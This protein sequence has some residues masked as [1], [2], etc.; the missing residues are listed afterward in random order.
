MLLARFSTVDRTKFA[1]ACTCRSGGGAAAGVA[2]RQ[3]D[4]VPVAVELA[5]F[6]HTFACQL[7]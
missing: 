4:R 1:M 2:T 7:L 6:T 3:L 5:L